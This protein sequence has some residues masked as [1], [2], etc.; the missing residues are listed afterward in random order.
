MLINIFQLSPEMCLK[1]QDELSDTEVT[2]AR[3]YRVCLGALVRFAGCS[4]AFCSFRAM[5]T[6][7]CSVYRFILAIMSTAPLR[8]SFVE[9]STVMRMHSRAI[10]TG[11][12]VQVELVC[13][14]RIRF[15]YTLG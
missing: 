8:D 2:I 3:Q 7:Y 10:P 14:W 4:T 15:S 5:L 13:E 11:L 6:A 1:L 12:G 9:L